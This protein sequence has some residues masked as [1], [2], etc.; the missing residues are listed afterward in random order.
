MGIECF[1]GMVSNEHVREAPSN[2]PPQPSV[3]LLL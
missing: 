2:L 1:F 3:A